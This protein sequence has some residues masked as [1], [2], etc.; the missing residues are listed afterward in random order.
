MNT[1]HCCGE[2]SSTGTLRFS[3]FLEFLIFDDTFNICFI[4]NRLLRKSR[5]LVKVYNIYVYFI[6]C[7]TV[8]MVVCNR[9]VF[10]GFFRIT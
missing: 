8:K 5:I 6:I 1:Q 3:V 9:G 7:I 2:G 4:Y 10:I